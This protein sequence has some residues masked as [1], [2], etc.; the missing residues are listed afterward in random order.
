MVEK[1]ILTNILQEVVPIGQEYAEI[2]LD[3]FIVD[4]TLRQIPVVNSIVGVLKLSKTISDTIFL[5]K[6]YNFIINLQDIDIEERRKFIERYEND[7]KNFSEKLICV[8][9]KLD[10]VDKSKYL[11]S[12]FKSYG[13]GKIDYHQFRRY[14]RALNVL[15]VDEM[16][17][18]RDHIDTKEL[19]TIYGVSL[20]NA[21]LGRVIN[22]NNLT[23]YIISNDGKKFIECVFE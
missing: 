4:D 7:E 21:G 13:R 8:I 16:T 3:S 5:K 20:L 22:A 9:D 23:D 1:D 15:N 17:Y 2:A 19:P 6:M 12:I 14:C 10:D 18:F 11:A